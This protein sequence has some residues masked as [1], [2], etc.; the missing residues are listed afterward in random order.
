MFLVSLSF[1]TFSLSYINC[2]LALY[3]LFICPCFPVSLSFIFYF[4]VLVYLFPCLLFSISSPCYPV[5]F[6]LYFL[7]PCPCFPVSLSFIFFLLVLVFLFLCLIFICLQFPTYL[8]QSIFMVSCFQ[9]AWFLGS[10]M[11][12][13]LYPYYT[14]LPEF[15]VW[16]SPGSGFPDSA[17]NDVSL[18][19]YRTKVEEMT[20]GEDGSLPNLKSAPNRTKSWL[21]SMVIL[22]NT[23]FD[24]LAN[25]FAKKS[26]LQSTQVLSRYLIITNTEYLL[27]YSYHPIGF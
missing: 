24:I 20:K 1:I 11:F 16:I 2:F 19:H 17:P 9:K 10:M 13:Y 15:P 8:S 12:R 4:L 7:F 21:W 25:I 3:F 14:I 26:L 5:L 23:H 22:Q 6:V 27:I 18:S